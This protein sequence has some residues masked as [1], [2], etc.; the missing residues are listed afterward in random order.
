MDSI[1]S[2]LKNFEIT[3]S[4]YKRELYLQNINDR[5]NA[6]KI[7]KI[8]NEWKIFP[9]KKSFDILHKDLLNIIFEKLDFITQTNL[10]ATHP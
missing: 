10:C 8:D 5:N 9:L 7:I 6:F 1:I 2:I 4:S 3:G